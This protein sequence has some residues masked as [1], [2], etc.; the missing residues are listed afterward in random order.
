MSFMSLLSFGF[1]LPDA[2]QETGVPSTKGSPEGKFVLDLHAAVG[3]AYGY[4]F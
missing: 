3:M 1:F 2:G 4:F